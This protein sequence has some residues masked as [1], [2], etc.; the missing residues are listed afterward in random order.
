MFSTLPTF[1][2]KAVRPATGDRT[3][4][5]GA[6]RGG[7][8]GEVETSVCLAGLLV[9]QGVVTGRVVDAGVNKNGP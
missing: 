9:P 7:V 4:A 2:H 1:D 3:E 6:P 8:P 5:G